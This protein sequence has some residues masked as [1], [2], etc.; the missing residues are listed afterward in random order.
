MQGEPA[1]AHPRWIR[2]PLVHFVA[3][4][5]LLFA[6]DRLRH[7][8]SPRR[9][10]DD[11]A[12]IAVDDSIRAALATEYAMRFGRPPDD[13]RLR[14]LTDDWIRDEALVR[15]AQRLGLDHGDPVIR[16]RL[17]QKMSLVIESRI[18]P[19]E[20]TEPEM[21]AWL[22]AHRDRYRLA[23]RT[24]FTHVF[25]S[26]ERRGDRARADATA[27][28]TTSDLSPSRGDAF[29]LGASLDGRTDADLAVGFGEAFPA[30]LAA[31]PIGA[32][33]GPITSRYGEHLVQVRARSEMRDATLA[34]V[35]TNVAADVRAQLRDAAVAAETQSIVGRYHV[36]SR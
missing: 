9:V 33:T 32:W 8:S 17:A 31:A 34:D 30:A 2:E 23:A 13:T 6:L 14:A 12:R 35:R 11:A 20:P 18:V 36:D 25:Y 1:R 29:A 5:A 16:R 3:I 24:S 10:S 4:G 27:A 21:I 28:L 7:R 26:R 22:A 19:R 15:E